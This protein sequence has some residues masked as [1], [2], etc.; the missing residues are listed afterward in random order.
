MKL[1][2]KH[3]AAYLPYELKVKNKECDDILTL[4]ELDKERVGSMDDKFKYVDWIGD[5][6]PILHPDLLFYG[7]MKCDNDREF[8]N[9][10][11]DDIA[12]ADAKMEVA[13]YH[14]VQKLLEWHFD[15]SGLIKEGLAIDVNNLKQNNETN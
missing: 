11:D 3:L 7:N 9:A 8:L 10:L 5:I 2:L 12:S 6:K 14:L 13:P 4:I 15:V 1:E